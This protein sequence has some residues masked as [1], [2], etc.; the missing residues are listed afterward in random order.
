MCDFLKT[1]LHSNWSCKTQS[2]TGTAF[3]RLISIVIVHLEI[4]DIIYINLILEK[5]YQM[6]DAPVQLLILDVK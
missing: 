3:S 4:M 1:L 2:K 5:L 6:E